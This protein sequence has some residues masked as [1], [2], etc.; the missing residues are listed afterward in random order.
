M[1]F[2]IIHYQ[3]CCILRSWMDSD[4]FVSFIF[5]LFRLAVPIQ[6]KHEPVFSPYT[7]EKSIK[8]MR[9]NDAHKNMGADD[10]TEEPH[11]RYL[12]YY[13]SHT[14]LEKIL[15]ADKLSDVLILHSYSFH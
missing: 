12:S 8:V 10:S 2:R 4:R 13:S 5:I 11:Q 6:S 9:D 1:T 14:S 15:S 7:P 3:N